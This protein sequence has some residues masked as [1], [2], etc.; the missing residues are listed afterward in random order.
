MKRRRRL[1][2]KHC[3]I[4]VCGCLAAI[5][6]LVISV[7]LVI[8]MFQNE[9][10]NANV[11]V[12]VVSQ[13]EKPTVVIDAGHGGYDN[14][15]ISYNGILEKDIDLSVAKKIKSALEYYGVNV[16]MTRSDDN[17]TWPEDNVADL[18]AR[19]SIANASNAS[20]FVSV[21]CNSTDL[22]GEVKGS[23]IYV[24]FDDEKAMALTEAINTELQKIEG[25]I[26]RE[27]KDASVNLLQLLV[28]N[29]IPSIIV[30]MGF[31]TDDEEADFLM[32][33]EG[34]NQLSMAIVRGILNVLGISME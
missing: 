25:L 23:E 11:D 17:V 8:G 21:H 22:A 6:L 20:Y 33:D 1:N 7:K 16:I 12:P 34:Q 18:R 9:E 13:A 31:L 32:S 27:P 5:A 30:E 14:G 2:I 10:V 19:S 24:Y 15:A 28:E 26:N 4:F 3:I 29:K